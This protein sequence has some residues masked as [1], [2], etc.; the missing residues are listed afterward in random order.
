MAAE[1]SPGAPA[2]PR[3]RRHEAWHAAGAGAG[4]A[5]SARRKGWLWLVTALAVP[6]ALWVVFEAQRHLRSDFAGQGAR[7]QVALWA[8]GQQRLPTPAQWQD[9]L[10]QLQKAARITP[11][12]P[13][14]QEALGDAWLVAGQMAMDDSTARQPHFEAAVAQY[15]KALD[16]RPTDA[17]LWAAL[18]GALQAAGNNGAPFHDAWA[19]ALALGPN[20]GH[21]R[22]LLLQ[23]ALAS[24]DQATPAMQQWVTGLY[25][26]ADAPARKAINRFAQGY[27]LRFVATDEVAPG[28]GAKP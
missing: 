20:E 4:T 22:P 19:R 21:V 10:E 5:A 17:N 7:K 8:S 1:R 9:A 18:A 26:A 16:L 27:G 3:G 25:E 15:R 11:E 12:S 28:D 6:A 23:A 13:V 24:W 14:A 2:R